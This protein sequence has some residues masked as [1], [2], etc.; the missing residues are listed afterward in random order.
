MLRRSGSRATVCAALLAAALT[1]S[2]TFPAASASLRQ[3]EVVSQVPSDLTPHAVNDPVVPNAAVKTYSQVGNLMYVGGHFHLLK[4]PSLTET[5]LRQN[6][7]AF[8]ITTGIPTGWAP[9]VNGPV[10][11]TFA[12]G[13]YLYVG[14][15][16]TVADGVSSQLV[17]YQ[18][19]TMQID[20]TWK[21]AG[22]E[23]KVTDLE[24]VS[25]RLVVA[26]S[27]PRRL[28]SLSLFT[29]ANLGYFTG[30]P[31]SGSVASNAGPTS[32]YRFA[33]NPA[34]TLLV[35]I[36]NFTVVGGIS[37]PRAFALNLGTTATVNTWY[38]LPL[39]KMCGFTTMPAYLRD[40]DFSPDG[41]YFV[42]VA[43][44]R[45]P[46]PGDLFSTI[47]DAAARFETGI[48]R[49][50]RPTWINYTG[51][52]SLLSVAATGPAVYVGGHQRW[53]DNPYGVD[54]CGT[55]CVPREGVGAIHPTTGKALSWNPGKSRGFG[56]SVIYPTPTGIWW[57]SDGRLFAGLVHDSIAYTPLP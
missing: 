14:G 39:G 29:G 6:L 20:T 56:T 9:R 17:R 1:G 55:G 19:A 52:D 5:F 4:G 40:V 16:F 47:C 24:V 33:V 37:R 43:I 50:T 8:S 2:L 54:T 41:A 27:F 15:E 36:G 23:G 44:G 31:I 51:G 35:A 21:P 3:S 13:G 11:T 38:Y 42:M 45:T 28:L 7:F 10:L 53:L 49:P 12:Y 30:L 34:R 26:G 18:L 57:G 22:I 48:P 46:R 32:V 25:G